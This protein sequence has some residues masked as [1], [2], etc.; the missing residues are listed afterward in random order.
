MKIVV[1]DDFHRTYETS[2]LIAGLRGF[3]DVKVFNELA[4]SRE[5]L[6]DRL[7]DVPIV[8]ANRERTHFPADLFRALP[9]L[10]LLCNTGGHLYHVDLAAATE[11]GVAV[12]LAYSTDPATTGISTAELTMALM[13]AVMRRIPQSDSAIRSAQWPVPLGHTLYG[14]TLGLLGLGRVG[15]HVARFAAAFNMHLLAWS[16]NL[17]PER[18]VAAGAEYRTL[19]ALLA[20]SDVVSI[21]LALS[22]R[23]RGLL[24]ES[25]LMKMRP[26]AY[27]VN[28]SRGAIIDEL[29][30]A[31]MLAANRIAGAALD[32]FVEEPLPPGHPFTGLPNLV[33]TSHLGWPT[34]LTYNTFA[35][36]CAHQIRKYL[37]GDYSGLENPEVLKGR[38]QRLQYP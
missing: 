33:L 5:E 7:H 1:L 10:D 36:D 22:D 6:L 3:A 35:A 27:L 25:R 8:I 26:S 9:R 29:A 2:P 37:G 28:T 20:E 18:A 38:P 23:T 12:V 15:S 34:D 14:K 24:T 31:R 21:H 17:T 19:D 13:M 4:R 30:L 16:A 11:A 32:V